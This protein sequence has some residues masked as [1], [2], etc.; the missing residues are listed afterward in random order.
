MAV[1]IN[2]EIYVAYDPE[3]FVFM[4]HNLSGEKIHSV[5]QIIDQNFV[6]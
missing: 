3:L 2:L 4:G 1:D 5:Y 6:L